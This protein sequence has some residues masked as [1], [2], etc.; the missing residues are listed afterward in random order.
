MNE[1]RKAK[2]R[3]DTKTAII[4]IIGGFILGALTSL[5]LP[6]VVSA[7]IGAICL[8][9]FLLQDI[10]GLISMISKKKSRKE[11]EQIQET[12]GEHAE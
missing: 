11:T 3:K 5:G 12:E 2:K 9:F 8:C 6:L 7:A 4:L 1:D 10:K